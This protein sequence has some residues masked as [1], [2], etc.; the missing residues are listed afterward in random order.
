MTT[1]WDRLDAAELLAPVC[2]AAGLP[3]GSI[4]IRSGG[5]K[6]RLIAELLTKGA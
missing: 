3:E 4:E 5:E 1:C 2:R 6:G